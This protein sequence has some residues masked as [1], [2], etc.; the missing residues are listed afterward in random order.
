MLKKDSNRLFLALAREG[1][2]PKLFV[3][4]KL[5][6]DHKR[7]FDHI[8]LKDTPLKFLIRQGNTFKQYDCKHVTFAPDYPV[9][10]TYP[11][12]YFSIED[13]EKAFIDWLNKHAKP[14]I[15]NQTEPDLWQQIQ[16][17]TPL[18]TGE[19]MTLVDTS[20]FTNEE[21][22]QIK[23]SINEF[24]VLVIKQFSPSTEELELIEGRLSYLTEAVGRLNRFDWRA[25]VI[26]AIISISIALTLDTESGRLL[27]DLFIKAFSSIAGFLPST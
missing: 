17:E 12:A 19:S 5:L 11:A 14:Y 13:L 7:F 6:S 25:V 16:L 15:A 18:V 4:K 2:D 20:Q 8:E 23:L 21:R 24:R 26:S 22:L 1:F 9:S 10:S 27:F 3:L